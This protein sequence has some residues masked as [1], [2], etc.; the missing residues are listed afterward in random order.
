[1]R[2]IFDR[3]RRRPGLH[4][5]AAGLNRD[6]ILSPVRP[7]PRTQPPPGQLASGKWAKSAVRAIL[8]NPRYTG[9]EVWNKQRKDEVLIDV[10]DVALGHVTKHALERHGPSGSGPPSPPTSRSSPRELFDAAQA[11]FDRN[12]RRDD[13]HA[14]RRPHYLLA[15]LMH[16][17]VCGRRMQGH[18]NHGRAYYRCKFPD[19]Y[20]DGDRE[21]PPRTSTS[22]R[23]PS[24]PAST[25]GSP[26]SSTRTTSTRP[27]PP[28]PAPPNPTPTP[29][30]READLRAAIAD[31]DR[32]LANYRA[33]LDT[34]DAV[35]V[36]VAWITD[37]QRERKAP[38]APT[39]PAD[40]G[41]RAHR[42]PGQSA[43]HASSQDIV[44]VLA[45]AD[46]ADKAELYDELGVAPALRPDGN[47]SVRGAP[48]WGT[49]TC[50]RGD[51][52]P[53]ALSGTSPSS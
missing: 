7:R 26:R 48:P 19:D 9:F 22:R 37:T 35:T 49:S 34:E 43:R 30:A 2:R 28:S 29:S 50:R 1:M 10:D 24:S 31:C 16:C 3:V 42:K 6:G 14:D 5:I 51:L 4:L 46:P 52:N 11:M 13:S 17:D 44:D 8:G 45:D 15:G 41:R 27:A 12:K 36:A 53:H 18:W 38:R 23:Q 25:R 39:R 32:K 47:V 40:P 33:L 21:H 20:P